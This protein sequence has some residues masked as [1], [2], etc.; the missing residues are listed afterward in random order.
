[1][2]SFFEHV[3]RAYSASRR[4]VIC[5]G[6][7]ARAVA[8]GEAVGAVVGFRPPAVENRQVQAAVEHVFW[9]LVPEASSGRRGL[10]S[11]TSTP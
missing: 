3:D 11:H 7:V 1:M 5:V 2:T 9:P 10:L 6:H 8:D 4:S